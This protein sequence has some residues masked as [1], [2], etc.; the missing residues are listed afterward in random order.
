[1]N[2]GID[3]LG[4]YSPSYIIDM[5]DLANARGIDP[6]KFTI[7]LGQ[8][9]MAIAPI[10]QDTITLG[11]NAAHEILTEED[12]KAIDLVIL[13][14]ESGIDYSKAGATTIHHLLGINPSARAI[15][16]KQACYA[17]TAGI[18]LAKNHIALYPNKK[19]LVIASDI[20]RYGINSAGE[21]TQGAG[22]LAILIS[23]DPKL[24]ALDKES[25]YH[26][27]DI[28]D[29]FRPLYSDVAIVD[30]K[31]SNDQ[32]QYFFETTFNNYLKET[33]R[34]IEDF[35]A[36]CFHIP[37]TKIGLK[38][39]KSITEDP[40]LIDT[41]VKSTYFNRQ[42]GNIYTGSLYLSVMSLLHKG[43]LE[44]NSRI[45]LYSYGSGAVAE[46]F[47]G[48]LQEGYQN[49]LQD[50][51]EKTLNQRTKLTIKEYETMF[52]QSLVT[53]GTHQV[54]DTSKDTGHFKLKEIK[55]HQ[56][57]YIED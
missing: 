10:T 53:N 5:K 54:L 48:T 39:L 23:H 28:H 45:G 29:F 33:D 22:A 43:N 20:S 26:T 52:N 37:Y 30:G 56:R 4:F 15:E 32:Y 13:A 49:H 55:H 42:V 35:E 57:H 2:I 25:S 9:I 31:Y 38:A 11:A 41:Y 47:S 3:K 40:K 1:M 17:A 19:A 14:T 50:N 21:P 34:T 7:G 46:F 12:K 27:E 8:D 51:L 6:N 24:I 18:Q 16:I 36:L 44:A